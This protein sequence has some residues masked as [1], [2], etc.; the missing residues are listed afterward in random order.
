MP[1]LD[2]K[3]V[4][5]LFWLALAIIF[6]VLELMTVGLTSIWVSLGSL[7]TCRYVF[8]T[9]RRWIRM[10]NHNIRNCDNYSFTF[11]KTIC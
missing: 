4:F 10:A 3:Y 11:Y 5:A 6:L 1:Y 9:I 2:I 8:C 7:A